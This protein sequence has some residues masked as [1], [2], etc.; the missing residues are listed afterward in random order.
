[1]I[2]CILSKKDSRRISGAELERKH[3]D[4]VGDARWLWLPAALIPLSHSISSPGTKSTS[5]LK[6]GEWER[7]NRREL[8][9][10]AA[11]FDE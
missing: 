6:H 2:S 5:I 3:W 9:G 4:R 11:G 7:C 8:T 10:L 1:M